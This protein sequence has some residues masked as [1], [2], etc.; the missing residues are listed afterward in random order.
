M[1][2][3]SQAR[4]AVQLATPFGGERLLVTHMTAS[5]HLSGLFQYDLSLVG[6]EGELDPDL[7]LG[8]PVKVTLMGADQ[9]PKRY[10]H[11]IVTKFAQTGFNDQEH[12]Y[13]ATVRPWFWF[14]TRT[15]DCRVF[16]NRTVP[17]IFSDVCKEAGFSDFR[18]DLLRKENYKPL[19]Y[20]VQYRETDFNF[21][22]RLLEQEGI[23]YFFEHL[24]DLHRL[25]LCDDAS[26]LS[27]AAGYAK[28]PFYAPS[29]PHARSD[30]DHLSS[31]QVQASF[32]PGVYA[33]REYNFVTPTPILASAHTIARCH[34][35]AGYEV[36]DWPAEPDTMVLDDVKRVAAVRA[37]ELQTGQTVAR[38][39][40][41]AR[42]L[43]VG[44][45]FT[46]TDH[47]RPS[48]NIDYVVSST[49]IVMTNDAFRSATSGGTGGGEAEFSISIEAVHAQEPYRP[50][51]NTPKPTVHGTQTAVV[52]GRAG[53]EICTDEHGRVKVQFHWDRKGKRN[54][55]SSCWIR[56][57]QPWAGKG[58][59]AMQIPRVGQEVVVSF[60]DGDPDRPII[61]G[62]VYNGANRPPFP[63]PANMTQSGVLSRSTPK[64]TAQNA[65]MLRFEDKKGAEQ[66]YLHAER[67]MDSVVEANDSLEVG[68]NRTIG[69]KGSHKEV[70]DQEIEITSK[71]GHV[72]ITAQT[73]I[74]LIVGASHLEMDAS[75]NIRIN[76]T[77]IDASASG[78]HTIKGG[79][80]QINP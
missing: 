77:V 70:V 58:W 80:V 4:R 19:E 27:A 29:N 48:L 2:V 46:L 25:V 57:A 6:Q 39:S 78:T 42:G 51:R 16:Q 33:T 26:R 20:C 65:N 64:G 30:T 31:W 14:L 68:G 71:N 12:E 55:D 44:A 69:V 75:G 34:D 18:D 24:P 5:E 36:F 72:Y 1:A 22:S 13:H 9:L 59:G 41:D 76:G 56:V 37:Q 62:S 28:V 21:L 61:V 52:V 74:H 38:G 50:A 45:M 47:P 3:Y 43:A 11:G 66:V 53:D 67:N 32:E 73:S 60:L 63:L 7:I 15:S 40:G 54:Q 35:A 8:Q 79:T 23:F 49:Y 17:Q 10:F